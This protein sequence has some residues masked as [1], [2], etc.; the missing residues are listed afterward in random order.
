MLRRPRRSTRTDTLFP[1]TTRFRAGEARQRGAGGAQEEDR[2]DQIA[3]SLLDRQRGELLVIQRAF[4]HHPRHGERQ[5]LANLL[6][7]EFGDAGVAAALDRKS[8]R[9]NSSH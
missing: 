2:L 1:Y 9:L 5:L 4:A 6:D 3:G 7:A 8:T